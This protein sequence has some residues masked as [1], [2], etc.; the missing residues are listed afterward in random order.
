MSWRDLLSKADERE[1]LPWVGGRT[2][3]KGMRVWALNGKLPPEH[4][5]YEFQTNGRKAHVLKPADRPEFSRWHTIRGFLVG[6]RFIRES[7]HVD[8]DPKT[9]RAASEELFLI[10]DTLDRFVLVNAARMSDDGP[11]LYAGMAMPLGVENDV[12]N[13]FLD[14]AP[15]LDH[16]KG[17]PPALDAAFRMESHQ[18]EE[19]DRRRAELEQ[20]RRIEE[21][22]R[23]AEERRQTL[24][25]KLGDAEG[26][27]E[28]AQIDFDEAAR[29]ALTVGGAEFIDARRAPNAN[30]MIVRYRLDHRRF[31]C[32]CD[33]YTLR[34]VDAGICLTDH[35]TGEKGDTRFTLESLPSVVREAI[36]EDVLHVFRPG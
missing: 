23:A 4:G 13:A 25:R 29:A 2:L 3:R 1:I 12:L 5:W 20:L 7:A 6:N 30:E 11:L 17:V 9:I 27:R 35:H 19:A 24:V 28:M 33:K 15:S 10:D 14:R 21:A 36:N 8:P 31:E 16:I 22:R 34:I 26:R 32:V 18:R